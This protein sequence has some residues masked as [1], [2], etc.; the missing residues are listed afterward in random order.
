MHLIT[1]LALTLGRL[2]A[3]ASPTTAPIT[4]TAAPA[5]F[6]QLAEPKAPAEKL[7]LSVARGKPDG[8]AS[9]AVHSVWIWHE[10]K[11]WHVRTTTKEAQHRFT[12]LVSVPDKSK[13]SGVKITGTETK[14]RVRLGDRSVHFD[15]T[16][17]GHEDGFDFD[18]EGE[19][20]V[21]FAVRVDGEAKAGVVKLGK[22]GTSPSSA[23]FKLCS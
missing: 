9:G 18:V 6:E 23:H 7:D 22:D 21:R 10:G 17:Q 12:G 4:T 1:M 14:D 11:H 19:G 16:T 8:L 3:D 15:F 2:L 5:P 20:C 13:I